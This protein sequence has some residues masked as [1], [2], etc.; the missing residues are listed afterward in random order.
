MIT[1]EEVY[2]E[3]LDCLRDV[4]MAQLLA[5]QV[6]V[7]ARMPARRD[8]KREREIISNTEKERERQM[9]IEKVR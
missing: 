1:A 2:V 6:G 5:R 3:R 4:Y 8:N 7:G 9:R